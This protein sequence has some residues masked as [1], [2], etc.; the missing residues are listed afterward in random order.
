M[1]DYTRCWLAGVAPYLM[2]CQP[3][4]L[5]LMIRVIFASE[6]TTMGIIFHRIQRDIPRIIVINCENMRWSALIFP[7]LLKW[8][9]PYEKDRK[10]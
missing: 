7:V 9:G 10:Y 3:L 6:T 1:A 4:L 8:W 2:Q 5:L